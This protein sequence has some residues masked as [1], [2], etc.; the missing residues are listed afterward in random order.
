MN[1]IKAITRKLEKIAKSFDDL[2]VSL[3]DANKV[4]DK[5]YSRTKHLRTCV[6]F[7]IGFIKA[8]NTII[9]WILTIVTFGTPFLIKSLISNNSPIINAIPNSAFYIVVGLM[10]LFLLW[11]IDRSTLLKVTEPTDELF[12]IGAYEKYRTRE[13]KRHHDYFGSDPLSFDELKKDIQEEVSRERKEHI[14]EREYY[15]MTLREKDDL[16]T[17]SIKELTSIREL[18]NHYSVKHH[19]L[20]NIFQE[21]LVK[22]GGL[23]SNSL[24]ENDLDFHHHFTIH[25]VESSEYRLLHVNHPHPHKVSKNYPR[26]GDNH[27]IRSSRSKDG[28]YHVK[29]EL[30]SFVIDGTGKD[31]WV[32]T[33]YPKVR[34]IEEVHS[35]EEYDKMYLDDIISLWTSFAILLK[36]D[37]VKSFNVKGEGRSVK[38]AE[39]R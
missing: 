7:F 21:V 12:N 29:G 35:Q 8:Q 17:K 28:Y 14:D 38:E 32:V 16:L 33:L 27:L 30:I 22:I 3:K 25:S 34:M 20:E 39:N 2:F 9:R 6:K 13:F 1:D 31:K 15:E 4:S 18:F 11:W 36:D 5:K 37:N 19:K 23:T 26:K 24:T 10:L